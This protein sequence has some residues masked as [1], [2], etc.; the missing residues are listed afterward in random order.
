LSMKLSLPI[1][2]PQPSSPSTTTPVSAKGIVSLSPPGTPTAVKMLDDGTLVGR[3][4]EI[5]S[6]AGAFL[7]AFW[8]GN[9]T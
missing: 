5:V 9:A 4:V 3:A 6:N 8:H 1:P 2:A 7:G